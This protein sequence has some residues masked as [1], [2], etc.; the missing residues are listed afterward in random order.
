[1]TSCETERK[2]IDELGTDFGR[3]LHD[4]E[5]EWAYVLYRY[6]EFMV[7]FGKD[8]RWVKLLNA[9]SPSFTHELQ[10][11]MSNALILGLC[12]LTDSSSRSVSVCHLPRLICDNPDLRIEVEC[13]VSR[14][15]KHACAARERRNKWIAHRDKERSD[16]RVT[17]G[18]IKAGLDAVHAAVNAVTMGYWKHHISN[19]VIS[20]QMPAMSFMVCLESLVEGVIYIESRIE[21]RGESGS[22]DDEVSSAFLRRIGG[23]PSKDLVKIQR[24]RMA[25]K[26]IKEGLD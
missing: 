24:L 20:R 7:L 26:T 11:E 18:D 8:K 13:H 12:R 3:M 2:Y 22:L 16:P 19:E 5:E 14:A 17:F 21:P 10:V 4:V 1:M 6:Q 23:D 15:Q 25:A 9:L